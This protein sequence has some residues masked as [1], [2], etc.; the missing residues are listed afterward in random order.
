MIMFSGGVT[1]VVTDSG[2][3]SHRGVEGHR[4]VRRV[5]GESQMALEASIC[6]RIGDWR[7]ETEGGGVRKKGG[8]ERGGG[9]GMYY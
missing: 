7:S 5:T 2:H 9:Q 1:L 4:G 8:E 3:S 6:G